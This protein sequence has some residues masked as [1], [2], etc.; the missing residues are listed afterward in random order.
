MGLPPNLDTSP[1]LYVPL[2]LSADVA[3]FCRCRTTLNGKRIIIDSPH[4]WGCG[5]GGGG[6]S[7][8]VFLLAL[9]LMYLFFLDFL[10]FF[11]Q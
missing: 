6:D 5:G 2:K 4:L 3:F 8:G 11:L 10:G 1:L 7:G 9:T